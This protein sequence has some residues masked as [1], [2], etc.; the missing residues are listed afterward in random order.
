VIAIG[1]RQSIVNGI[2]QL[3]IRRENER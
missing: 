1:G 3:Q 2:N